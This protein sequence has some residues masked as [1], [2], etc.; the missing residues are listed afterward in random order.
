MAAAQA[1]A[2]DAVRL[3]QCSVQSGGEAHSVLRIRRC[4]GARPQQALTAGKSLK[5][6]WPSCVPALQ[7]AS[8]SG[9]SSSRRL[10]TQCVSAAVVD[11]GSE[12]AELLAAAENGPQRPAPAEYARTLVESCSVGTL[13][14]LSNG[15]PLGTFVGY[16]LDSAGQPLLRLREA[17]VKTQNILKDNR[18]SLYVQF[19]ECGTSVPSQ[20]CTLM[21]TVTRVS[22]DDSA[23]C[24]KLYSLKH[25]VENDEGYAY[26]RINVEKALYVSDIGAAPNRR[27]AWVEGEDYK[28]S[29]SDPLR[30]C[31]QKIIAY[32]NSEFNYEEVVRLCAC[33]TGVRGQIEAVKVTSLDR[34][35]F[36]MRVKVVGQ[37]GVSDVRIRFPR[38]VSDER[39]ARSTLT[40]MA[41][42][43][44]EKERKYPPHPVI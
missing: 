25:R 44:W 8:G 7:G 31:A 16:G 41:Q 33:Y 1:A 5:L 32:H 30:D 37:D 11:A 19:V 14:T 20:R 43:A 42:L 4:S 9:S 35:G 13:S 12:V 2:V 18:C 24:A 3:S 10:V 17:A 29:E 6:C 40:M 23:V 22:D 34:L 21:G 39:D 28:N 36:D 27:P 15:W 26:Y 38:E